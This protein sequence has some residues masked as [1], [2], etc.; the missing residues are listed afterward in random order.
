MKNKILTIIG[1]T[2]I[3]KTA[4]A[5]E[6]AKQINGDLDCLLEEGMNK[7]KPAKT[8]SFFSYFFLFSLASCGL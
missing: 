6:L 4:I 1:P 7:M 2:A 8:I 5:I 3:G